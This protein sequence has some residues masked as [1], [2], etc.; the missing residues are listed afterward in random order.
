[1][2]FQF[3]KV[4][5]YHLLEF[6]E[7]TGHFVLQNMIEPIPNHSCIEPE[8]NNGLLFILLTT[9]YMSDGE[10]SEGKLNIVLI[11]LIINN[12]LFRD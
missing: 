7:K 3:E 11:T 1:L 4:F 12:V 9:I 10:I 5:G 6:E 2:K 8:A